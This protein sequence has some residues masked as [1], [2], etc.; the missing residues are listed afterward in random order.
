MQLDNVANIINNIKLVKCSFF[1]SLLLF[2][3]FKSCL[4]SLDDHASS[5][6]E[7][8]DLDWDNL[9]FSIVPADYMYIMKCS[10]HENFKQGQ[11]GRYGNI[12]LSPSAAVLNYGQASSNSIFQEHL[13]QTITYIMDS[14]K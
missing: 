5:D 10:K 1:F 13:D 8:A 11:L 9:G 14:D 3:A 4:M 7:Y 2:Y 6:D 12:E